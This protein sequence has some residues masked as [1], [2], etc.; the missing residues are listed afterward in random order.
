MADKKSYWKN[1][2]LVDT[3]IS[4]RLS[5]EFVSTFSYKELLWRVTSVAFPASPLTWVRLVEF[6]ETNPK[7]SSPNKTKAS[8]VLTSHRSLTRQRI[9]QVHSQSHSLWPTL[10]Y[11]LQSELLIAKNS[12]KLD[13]LQKFTL[14]VC[15]VWKNFFL[16]KQTCFVSFHYL[17]LIFQF[18]RKIVTLWQHSNAGLNHNVLHKH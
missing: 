1:E 8:Y 2:R 15:Y 13:K 11:K 17:F 12:W 3:K 9:L 6:K 4:S 5:T 10:R 14:S 18:I 16:K 7:G